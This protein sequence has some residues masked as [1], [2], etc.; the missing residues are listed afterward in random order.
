M[1]KPR[2]K[3]LKKLPR[4]IQTATCPI[5][6]KHKEVCTTGNNERET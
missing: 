3:R 2:Q 5:T 1:Q 4:K 6:T